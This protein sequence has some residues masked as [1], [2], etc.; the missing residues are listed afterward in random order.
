MYP[1]YFPR[2]AKDAVVLD[3]LAELMNS[4]RFDRP[5]C[6]SSTVRATVSTIV[7]RNCAESVPSLY[8]LKSRPGNSLYTSR[9]M[10]TI[11]AVVEPHSQLMK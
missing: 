9:K 4:Q 3:V 5:E 6:A 1:V 11:F 10:R 8:S 7:L 2:D